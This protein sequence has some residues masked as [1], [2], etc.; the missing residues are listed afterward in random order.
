MKRNLWSLFFLFFNLSKHEKGAKLFLYWDCKNIK[1]CWT[2]RTWLDW[3]SPS[4]GLL[5][6]FRG[7]HPKD[8][9]IDQTYVI[10]LMLVKNKEVLIINGWGN[11][12]NRVLNLLMAVTHSW[13]WHFHFIFVVVGLANILAT[14][15][16]HTMLNSSTFRFGSMLPTPLSVVDMF[17]ISHSVAIY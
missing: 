3:A 11:W 10:L 9:L 17:K 1:Q 12:E 2:R 8:E 16:H 4:Q 14:L 13:T 6:I 15:V 7:I 5:K